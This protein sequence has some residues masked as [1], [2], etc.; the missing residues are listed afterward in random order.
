MSKKALGTGSYH[1]VKDGAC[2]RAL[3]TD[4]QMRASDFRA[5]YYEALQGS[6]TL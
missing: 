1:S 6:E 3:I 5:S 4:Y 2:M